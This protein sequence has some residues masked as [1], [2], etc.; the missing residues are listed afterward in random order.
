MEQR[1]WINFRIK[2]HFHDVNQHRFHWN[3]VS[4]SVHCKLNMFRVVHWKFYERTHK[5]R[6]LAQSMG[7]PIFCEKIVLTDKEISYPSIR[8][9][10]STAVF[11][12]KCGSFWKRPENVWP[13]QNFRSS[14]IKSYRIDRSVFHLNKMFCNKSDH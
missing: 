8:F 3:L 9:K 4:S 7:F 10:P 6:S 11:H 12:K 14:T 13:I 5:Y 1:R 2:I